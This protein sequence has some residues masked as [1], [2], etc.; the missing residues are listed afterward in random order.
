MEYKQA[1]DKIRTTIEK[2]KLE[3]DARL[4]VGQ[5]DYMRRINKNLK[6]YEPGMSNSE[7][8]VPLKANA[9]SVLDNYHTSI[10]SR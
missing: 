1:Q 10:T 9:K 5:K 3:R 6:R 2:K 4:M 8:K 7:R